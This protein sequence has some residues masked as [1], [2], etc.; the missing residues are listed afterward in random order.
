MRIAELI[1]KQSIG[2]LLIDFDAIEM[3]EKTGVEIMPFSRVEAMLLGQLP[4][5]HRD[6]LRLDDHCAIDCK[7]RARHDG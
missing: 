7:C 4:L 3:A 6:P 5:H 1:I 2:K